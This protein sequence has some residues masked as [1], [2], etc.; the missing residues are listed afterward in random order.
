MDIKHI[1]PPRTRN[2]SSTAFGGSS[3]E[4]WLWF[5]CKGSLN[6]VKP[7]HPAFFMFFVQFY[8]YLSPFLM[9]QLMAFFHGFSANFFRGMD[10]I[11]YEKSSDL[12]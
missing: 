5:L 9:L 3:H 10:G 6:M 7:L 8:P 12:K 2:S 11:L 4:S 1:L